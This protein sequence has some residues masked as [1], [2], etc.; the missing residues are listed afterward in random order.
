MN[1]GPAVPKPAFIFVLLILLAG[2]SLAGAWYASVTS[3]GYVQAQSN[4]E[5]AAADCLGLAELVRTAESAG[6][7]RQA[8]IRDGVNR[9]DARLRDLINSGALDGTGLGERWN[10][11]LRDRVLRS[12]NEA[13]PAAQHRDL[14]ARLQRFGN[15][16]LRHSRAQTGAVAAATAWRNALMLTALLGLAGLGAL[17]WRMR[18]NILRDLRAAGAFGRSTQGAFPAGTAESWHS[19]SGKAGD[20]SASVSPNLAE[21]GVGPQFAGVGTETPISPSQTS[22]ELWH[23]VLTR[24]LE[25]PDSVEPFTLLLREIEELTGAMSSAIVVTA[26]PERQTVL[27][28]C[29]YAKDRERFADFAR[30]PP[31]DMRV[32][33]YGEVHIYDDPSV[34]GYRFV[35]SRLRQGELGYGFLL[36]RV[37][38]A[39]ELSHS[40]IALL[41]LHGERLASIIYG[42]RRARQTLRVAQYQER[43][44]IA[45]ELHDSLAQSLSYLKIQAARLQSLMGRDPTSAEHEMHDEV[46]SVLQ[47]LRENL[48]V[49]YRQLRELI[50]TFRLTMRGRSFAQ[51]LEDSVDEFAKRSSIAFDVDNRLPGGVLSVAEE[52]QLLQ[53]IREALSN[54]VRHSHANYAEVSVSS[55][56]DGILRVT[57]DDDGIGVDPSRRRARNHG[58]IIMQERAQSLKGEMRI[59]KAPG[60]G[61][62]VLVQFRPSKYSGN[63]PAV[64]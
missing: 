11:G 53:I 52:L 56:S 17:A 48:N 47:E 35:A 5:I 32:A 6:D 18:H 64:I 9:I 63:P 1:P 49:A 58:I 20:G 26:G 21:G 23:G 27:L 13:K 44:A 54:A 33:G 25:D 39:I 4:L 38:S 45:R 8:L 22:L 15:A 36:L 19:N 14:V 30:N 55:A 40:E 57:I 34:H 61:T 16:L 50:T 12:A 31:A 7:D 3:L 43:A 41:N 51:A 10:G 59:E 28:A 24:L 29:T 60:G 2:G 37:P 46:D 62:R 42:T